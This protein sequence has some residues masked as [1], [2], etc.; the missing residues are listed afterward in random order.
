MSVWEHLSQVQVVKG[1]GTEMGGQMGN[2]EES[3][4]GQQGFSEMRVE[5][6]YRK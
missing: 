3:L 4:A 2:I 1:K 5:D 6:S